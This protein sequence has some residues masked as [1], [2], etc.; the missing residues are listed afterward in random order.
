MLLLTSRMP[1]VAI[2]KYQNGSPETSN[3]YPEA[4]R[5]HP[6]TPGGQ[7]KAPSDLFGLQEVF[8]GQSL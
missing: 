2:H 4:P 3:G 1:K 7:P 8:S 5:C 6:D